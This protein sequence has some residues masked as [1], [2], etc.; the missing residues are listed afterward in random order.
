MMHGKSNIKK[1]NYM[2]VRLQEEWLIYADDTVLIL[3]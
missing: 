1:S 2:V 3:G